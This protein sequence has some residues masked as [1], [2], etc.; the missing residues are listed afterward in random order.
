MAELWTNNAATT[1]AS[2]LSAGATSL[3][4]AAGEGALFPNPTAPDFFYSTL[5]NGTV[6]EIVKVTA[7]STD[8]F[9]I[10]RAQ[11]GTTDLTWLT[12]DAFELRLTRGA[13]ESLRNQV[14][15]QGAYAPGGYTVTTGRYVVMVK[16][17]E[18]TGTE[19]LVL[20][21]TARLVL[22]N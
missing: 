19:R 21:G 1:L 10:V 13:L 4:V 6:V 17:L 2:G 20:E 22:Q 12:G 15:A 8:V 11:Q 5:D 7:R 16:R 9:T 18:L 3:T 14:L